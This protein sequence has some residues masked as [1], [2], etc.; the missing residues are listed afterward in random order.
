MRIGIVGCGLNSDYH[1]NFAGTYQGAKIVGIADRDSAKAREC[2]AK[3]G[4]AGIYSGIA[5]LVKHEQPDVVHIVTPP[6]AHYAL[7]KEA[8]ELKCHVLVE[9]PMALSL[10]EAKELFGLADRHRVKLCT[11]H[12]HFFDPCMS[13]ARDHVENGRA[14][15]II[16]VESYYGLNTRIPA[17]REYPAP[18]VI[19]WLYTLPGGV[20]H[21]FMAHPLYVLLEYT[22]RPRE[23]KVM[24]Q[25]HGV[26]PWDMPDELRILINGEKA[27]GTVTFSF[28][29]RPHLHFVRIY[30]TKMMAEVDFNTMVTVT[31]PVSPLP[32]AAQKALY[33]ISGSRQ[34]FSKTV[35]NTI[36][37][38]RGK[39]K[40]YQGMEV[41]IHKF[42]DSVK[43]NS[44]PPV[45][46][47]QALLVIETM[48]E[49]WR[50]VNPEQASFAPVIPQQAYALKHK[51]K[52]LVTGGT[53]F[54]GA[55]LVERLAAYGYTVRVLAR[56]LANIGR[57]KK[58]GV[59]I[60]FGDV[61]D[62]ESLK[63]LFEGIDIVIHAAAGTSGSK[64]DS[65]TG[66]IQGTR[67]V[68]E[69]SEKS[70]IQ[71][72]VYIS[73]CSVYGVADYKANQLVSEDSSLER[74]PLKRGAYSASKQQAEGLV[75]E[76]M[77]KNKFPVV[78]LRPGT[79]YGPGGELFTPMMGFSLFNKAFIVIGNGKF[80][81]PI[82]YIDN[83]V[84][85]ITASVRSSKADNKIFNVVDSER[86]TKR[87]YIR[88]L[89]KRLYPGSRT[90]YFPYSLFYAVTWA[91]EILCRVL[92]REPFLS[93]YRLTSSQRNIRYDN[94]RIIGRL[95]WRPS[96][97]FGEAVEAIIK[98]ERKDGSASTEESPQPGQP[99]EMV[100]VQ[101]H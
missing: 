11:M 44:A 84:E 87:Q 55:R 67:N 70:R 40:G 46:R 4:I 72:F 26:L 15:R 75:M 97:S 25:S 57:L 19:P 90:I 21:D 68:L 33:N 23:I 53:G 28:A 3:H 39:L 88:K 35:S 99:H 86:I 9:K 51:E 36:N 1:I 78:I 93:R 7:V 27:F 76:A 63:P 2:G 56:K 96:V 79:I 47:Q 37:F 66:T 69:M 60:F 52:I 92:K 42:Y 61:A 8:L 64:R 12:N 48:D 85:A 6:R 31:H 101:R 17:F 41:L 71:K 38:V 83:L 5:E 82:V 77:K 29:A 94:S 62:K 10:R 14:G 49:I 91:Q 95:G 32:K 24:K 74:Q 73:S 50:Q 59:E 89:M 98:F 13:E 16:N 81:L 45:T 80:E 22:G 58:L 34:L 20:Y 18:G 43:Q 30:G 65:E 100:A 54:L